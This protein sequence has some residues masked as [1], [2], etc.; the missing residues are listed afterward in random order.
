MIA[1]DRRPFLE[2]VMGFAELKGKQ[3]SAPALELYWRSM[4]DWSLED[5]QAA[6]AQLIKTSEFMP[7]PKSF[8]DLRKAGRPTAAE[9]WLEVRKH[10]VWHFEGYTLSEN[11]PPLIAKVVRALGGPHRIAMTPEDQLPFVERRFA[12]HYETLEDATDIREALPQIAQPE[13]LR[14]KLVAAQKRFTS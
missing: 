12:E 2:I 5:F 9:A 8:E 13:R 14:L 7:T 6:A 3:L 1:T 4:Q 10:L 11:C